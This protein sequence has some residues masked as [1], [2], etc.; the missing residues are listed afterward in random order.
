M[1]MREINDKKDSAGEGAA[2]LFA[3]FCRIIAALRGEHGCPWDR[4]QTFESLKP[5][6]VNEMT[7]AVA[8]IDL[9][10]GSGKAENLCEELGDVL[11]Q[12][13]LLSRIAQEEGLF[14]VEDVIAGVS[15]K[16]IRR[17][18][19]VF[20]TDK[21]NPSA[22]VQNSD[23]REQ[24]LFAPDSGVPVCAGEVPGLW[25]AIKQTEKKSKSPEE[26]QDEKEAFCTAAEWAIMHLQS[27]PKVMG[28]K[29]GKP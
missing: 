29:Q 3:D 4:E 16:M 17:H 6:M 8:G 25:E 24:P 14:S 7:E 22:M 11:L 21:D 12:V 13:V 10:Y 23:V 5:C 9:Y 20:G 18:P 28:K 15:Q 19:H 27:H 2:E 1:E 26:I